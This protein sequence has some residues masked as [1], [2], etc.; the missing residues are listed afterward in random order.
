MSHRC[1]AND[2]VEFLPCKVPQL[3]T[4][5]PQAAAILIR[6]VGNFCRL[7][8]PEFGTQCRDEHER[9]FDVGLDAVKVEFDALKQMIDKAMAGIM[10]HRHRMKA[11]VDDDRFEDLQ[12]EVPCEP[13][14]LTPALL[15]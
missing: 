12:L 13:A 5:F 7:V 8:V 3:Q 6:R 9:G 15:P 4:G 2:A 10:N 14:K 11:I 1:R